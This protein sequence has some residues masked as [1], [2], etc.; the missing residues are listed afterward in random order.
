[1]NTTMDMDK[2]Q[3]IDCEVLAARLIKTQNSKS[4]WAKCKSL[5]CAP[6]FT[7]RS[8]HNPTNP[9][10]TPVTKE[11]LEAQDEDVKI[12]SVEVTFKCKG[13]F[14]S[15]ASPNA[16]APGRDGQ[17][18]RGADQGPG[19]G[20]QE[21]RREQGLFSDQEVQERQEEQ[22]QQQR[23]HCGPSPHPRA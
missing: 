23:K 15:A 10:V 20:V 7:K 2:T 11:E 18:H 21:V 13:D 9:P 1:M 16:K 17:G 22:L 12:T 8:G 19:P 4:F 3:E 14:K 5:C 6:F